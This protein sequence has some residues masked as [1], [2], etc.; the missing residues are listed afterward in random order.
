MN[1]T[2]K[3]SF[4][5][6]VIL[7]EFGGPQV[8]KVKDIAKPSIKNDEVLIQVKSVGICHHDIM[9]RSGL[10][11]GAKT[12]V[13]LG[14]ETSG[15]IVETGSNVK[16]K[17]IGDRVVLYQRR[18]CNLCRNCLRGRQDMCKV[19]GMPGVD[20]EGGYAEFV[21]IPEISTQTI[22]QNLP[23]SSAALSSC[24]IGTSLRAVKTIG[25]IS[26]GD[27]VLITGA[28]GGLGVHQIQLVKAFGGTS[29]A[30]TSSAEKAEQ[31]KLI[32]ADHVVVSKDN[33]F[34]AEVWK[35]TDKLGIDIAIE[36]IGATLPET[37]RC[38]TQGG[39]V[40]VLGNIG[41]S[42][43]NLTPGLL[44]GRRL[45][46][47]GSGSCTFEDLKQSI[48]MLTSGVIKPVIAQTFKFTDVSAAHTLIE[49][50]KSIGR[51]VLEGWN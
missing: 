40:V 19:A 37:L 51:V 25:N 9:H 28:S 14:H 6:A 22:P 30:V 21:A 4:M 1:P 16:N 7:E 45:R 5:K 27:T 12:G 13:I 44:I 38:M 35:L 8:L 50:K 11:P 48:S 24:P 43:I 34:S 15:E 41:A 23:W 32:G 26:P 47:V 2:I 36:N 10:I 42:T 33:L 17:K 29:I 39:I 46:V 18:F 3:V 49:S 20:T 31:L